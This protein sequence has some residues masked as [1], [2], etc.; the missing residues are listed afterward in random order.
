MVE[1]CK[2]KED[3]KE[4][5][6]K[7]LKPVVP[8]P[9]TDDILIDANNISWMQIYGFKRGFHLHAVFKSENKFCFDSREPFDDDTYKNWLPNMGEYNS[10]D[11]LIEG[12]SELYYKCWNLTG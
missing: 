5:L 2:T 11:D 10:M 1:N 6:K 7:E 12:V 3:I 4:W 8:E 9:S